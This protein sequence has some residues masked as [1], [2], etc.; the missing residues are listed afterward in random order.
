[1]LQPGSILGMLLS[2]QIG[3]GTPKPCTCGLTNHHPHCDGQHERLVRHKTLFPD[4]LKSPDDQILTLLKA[5]VVELAFAN[6][7]PNELFN[8]RLVEAWVYKKI[9][10]ENLP[11]LTELMDLGYNP[12]N[13]SDY[14][15]ILSHPKIG[16]LLIRRSKDSQIAIGMQL[17]ADN[18][19]H[20]EMIGLVLGENLEGYSTA[21]IQEKLKAW[22]IQNS[23]WL[24]HLEKK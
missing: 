13:V 20:T 16:A 12:I 11:V 18:P 6:Q 3:Q 14:W 21:L 4:L 22:K 5:K 8:D 7:K 23:P 19:R 1:M 15:N 17:S 24:P 9:E 2:S 10:E